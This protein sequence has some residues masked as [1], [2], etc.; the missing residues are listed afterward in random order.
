VE[1]ATLSQTSLKIKGKRSS[2]V[3]DPDKTLKAKTPAEAVVVFNG[4][5]SLDVGKI[6]G[7]RVVISGSGEYEVGGIKISG[8]KT[9][10][11]LF[12][13]MLVDGVTVALANS[14]SINTLKE[15]LTGHHILLF[16]V[17]G[18]ID[19]ALIATLEPRVVIFYGENVA[20]LKNTIKDAIP[21]QKYAVTLEKLPEKMQTVILQ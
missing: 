11:E 5:Q 16:C 1:I 19:E 7:Q 13:Q 14:N 9:G 20:E 8:V 3:I 15:K 6:E 17:N 10:G 18:K 12:Y 2:F 4:L 21:M